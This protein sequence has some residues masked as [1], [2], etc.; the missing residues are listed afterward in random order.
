MD[1]AEDEDGRFRF[2]RGRGLLS[3]ERQGAEDSEQPGREDLRILHG[4]L[5][6]AIYDWSVLGVSGPSLLV[7]QHLQARHLGDVSKDPVTREK[8]GILI[9]SA[10]RDVSIRNGDPESPL[11][12][13]PSQ[14]S[15]PDP[16]PQGGIG[17]LQIRHEILNR[18][19]VARGSSSGDQL[20][21]DDRR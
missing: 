4:C 15:D 1:G 14:L 21:N 11:I 12:E 18:G 9:E 16:V 13:V 5:L 20:G 10:L 3:G 19:P 17:D 2:R 7:R 6:R 8:P